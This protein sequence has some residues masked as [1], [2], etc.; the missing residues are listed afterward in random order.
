MFSLFVLSLLVQEFSAIPSDQCA[1]H[2]YSDRVGVGA[3]R[4]HGFILALS[5]INERM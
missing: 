2:A 5:T 1:L 4:G 3:G